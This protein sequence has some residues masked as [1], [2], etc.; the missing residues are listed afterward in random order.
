MIGVVVPSLSSRSISMLSKS[1]LASL[2]ESTGVFPFLTMCFGPRTEL[3][4]FPEMTWPVTSQSK[5][6]RIAARCCFFVGATSARVALD[7]SGDGHRVDGLERE[8]PLLTPSE[9]LSYGLGVGRSR[10]LVPDVGG[11]ELE[12]AAC[13]PGRRLRQSRPVKPARSL[14]LPRS[15]HLLGSFLETGL[16]GSLACVGPVF[17][18]KRGPRMPQDGRLSLGLT[19]R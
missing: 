7:V 11:E 2:A 18:K 1:V 3:A 17:C 13:R 12:E 16:F 9:E 10:V 4:G 19:S 15:A 8:P 5:S 6:I 14:A